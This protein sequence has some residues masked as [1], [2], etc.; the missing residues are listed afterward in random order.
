MKQ[1]F[2]LVLILVFSS[3]TLLNLSAETDKAPCEKY[4]GQT[5][6]GKEPE[7]FAPGLVS[8][9]LFEMNAA[10]SPKGDLF[11]FSIA[12][13]YQNFN[14]ILM[15]Q[16]KNGK[17]SAPQVAPF[18]GRYSDFDPVFSSDGKKLFFISRRPEEGKTGSKEDTDIWVM[19]VKD[20][21]FSEPV[22]M[23]SPVNSNSD[24]YY[25]SCSNNG[26]LYFTS[27]REGGKGAWDIYMSK[28]LDGVYRE[29]EDMEDSINSKYNEHDPF[30]APD[31][32]YIIFTSSRPGGQGRGDLYIS[33]KKTDNSW[34]P[35][36]NLG[37]GINSPDYEYCPVVSP[38]GKYL[39]FSRF[40][41]GTEKFESESRRSYQELS[42]LFTGKNNGLGN[43]YWVSFNPNDYFSET[44]GK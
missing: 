18:S 32:S 14:A 42:E 19:D 11:L 37:P 3:I 13:P 28:P 24:E 20:S 31:E 2:I 15:M 6:P 7:L 36:K 27:T 26:T 1:T 23:P 5:P 29:I 35:A 10:I 41:G 34:T 33:F 9:G 4:L 12:D 38:D 44:G 8:T 21:E 39:F 40:G 30:I 22:C 17:W 16:F 43:I 25:A